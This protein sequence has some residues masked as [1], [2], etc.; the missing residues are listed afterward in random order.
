MKKKTT[1]LF[2]YSFARWKWNVQEEGSLDKFCDFHD[3]HDFLLKKQ[4]LFR[5]SIG[6]ISRKFGKACRLDESSRRKPGWRFTAGFELDVEKTV[7]L[8][9]ISDVF[10]RGNEFVHYGFIP[11]HFSGEVQW[12]RKPGSYSA[13]H[14]L[15]ESEMSR[16]RE[17]WVNL[18]IFKIFGNF[19]F[20]Q[21]W[22]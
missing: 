12:K 13:I 16:T 22:I 10:F 20:F 15:D 19:Y 2:G 17:I 6:N 4:F 18:V 7:D 21:K 3:F 8:F 14:L 5:N 1:E 11:L 9:I